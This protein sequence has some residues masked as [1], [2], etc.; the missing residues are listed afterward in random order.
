MESEFGSFVFPKEVGEGDVG[1]EDAYL[2]VKYEYSN[3]SAKGKGVGSTLVGRKN[4]G[5]EERGRAVWG[6]D[7]GV[8]GRV[9]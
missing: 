2:L 1:T 9:G 4:G 6:V 7:C 5:W 3:G 8:R